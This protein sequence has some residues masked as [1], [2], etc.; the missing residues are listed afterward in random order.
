M[1][2]YVKIAVAVVAGFVV[3]MFVNAPLRGATAQNA[4]PLEGRLSHISFAVADVEETAGAFADVFGVEMSES[5]DFR[6]IPWGPRF[7]GKLMNTRRIGLDIN[8]VS[9]E[10]L[11]PLEGESPWPEFID[12]SGEG[13]HHI[14]F[15]VPDVAA[16]R[17]YLESKGGVQTQAYSDAANYVDMTEGGL[18][19]TFEVTL[20]PQQQQ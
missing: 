8:G 1:Q 3:G 9:F 11:Q 16:A 10:F 17:A 5:Q 12:R 2:G 14:G 6:D 4:N 13:V 19:I 20:L 18:P 15:S 7:P